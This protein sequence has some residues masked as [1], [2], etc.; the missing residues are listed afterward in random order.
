[1]I[2]AELIRKDAVI[3][4]MTIDVG[5]IRIALAREDM[6]QESAVIVFSSLV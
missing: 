4:L 5:G 2:V 6:S 3:V 1:L